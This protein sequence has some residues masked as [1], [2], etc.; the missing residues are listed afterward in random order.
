MLSNLF[1][2]NLPR[3]RAAAAVVGVSGGIVGVNR[4]EQY[5]ND[6]TKKLYLSNY[7]KKEIDLSERHEKAKQKRYAYYD[8]Q[9]NEV[10][11]IEFNQSDGRIDWILVQDEKNRHRGLG[12]QMIREISKELKEDKEN[13][14]NK[15]T[16][17]W[18]ITPSDEFAQMYREGKC[19]R[20]SRGDNWPRYSI[21][22][23][24]C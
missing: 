9:N 4:Y 13:D 23:E 24:Y 20:K 12:K 18:G 8:A 15:I 3:F 5:K 21:E 11:H 14:K 1:R 19:D 22:I 7:E 6:K 2:R 16:H 10:C 17:I